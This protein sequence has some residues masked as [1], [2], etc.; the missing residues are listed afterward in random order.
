MIIGEFKTRW[1]YYWFRIKYWGYYDKA[2]LSRHYAL[3]IKFNNGFWLPLVDCMWKEWEYREER[4]SSFGAYMQM[5][6][7]GTYGGATGIANVTGAS[8]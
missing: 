8:K 1:Q 4:R 3:M 6:S 5:M 2:Y 7:N